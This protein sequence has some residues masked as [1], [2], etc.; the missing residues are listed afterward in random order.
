VLLPPSEL[1]EP[2]WSVPFPALPAGRRPAAPRRRAAETA[3]GFEAREARHVV[4]VERWQRRRL[5][6]EGA[7]WCA[8]RAAAEWARVVPVL[9]RSAGLDAVDSAVVLD[10]CTVVARL[11]WCE[12]L[13]ST[14]GLVVTVAKGQAGRNPLTIV[15]S[16]YRQQIRAYIGELG[17][18][19]SART[20]IDPPTRPSSDGPAG[21]SDDDDDPFD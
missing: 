8:T 7:A 16:Q 5:A 20:R 2:D 1:V 15:A 17:L 21:R 10:Y 18:S 14:E 4:E 19:P 13:I 6:A 9:R 3:E 12:R 11:E